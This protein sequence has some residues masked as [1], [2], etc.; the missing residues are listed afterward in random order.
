KELK[1]VAAFPNV[2]CKLSGLVTEA[3]HS[4]WKLSELKP[5]VEC[6]LELFGSNRLLF[7]SDYPVCL[8]ASSYERVLGS[9]QELLK[10]LGD[11]E[12]QRIFRDNAREFYRL[13]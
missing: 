11:E 3:N 7:G 13:D 12:H 9:F 4:S 1:A 10:D 5:F 8:L 6:A 2:Y